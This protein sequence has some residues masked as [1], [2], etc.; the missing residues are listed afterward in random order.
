MTPPVASICSTRDTRTARSKPLRIN[1]L[2]EVPLERTGLLLL[3]RGRSL[4]P[5]ANPQRPLPAGLPLP[6]RISSSK[7]A[8]LEDEAG[9]L[10]I[11]SSIWAVFEDGQVDW[12]SHPQYERFLR[13]RGP[14]IGS[15]PRIG[16]ILRTNRG[17]TR[18]PSRR[19]CGV[20][21]RCSGIFAHSRHSNRT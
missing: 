8:T 13:T 10:T 15:R 12:L 4:F 14:I 18:G 17:R 6:P 21:G 20:A 5:S 9:R 3:C 1:R 19:R 16:P 7:R 11:S 2:Q